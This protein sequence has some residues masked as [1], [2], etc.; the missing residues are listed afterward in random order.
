MRT[1]IA[2]LVAFLA[3]VAHADDRVSVAILLPIEG[4]KLQKHGTPT[5]YVE[6]HVSPEEI[7]TKHIPYRND[8]VRQVEVRE[9]GDT[10]VALVLLAAPFTQKKG[11]G[12]DHI[13]A[14]VELPSKAVAD[15]VLIRSKFGDK[16]YVG[17][18]ASNKRGESYVL[19]KR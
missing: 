9:Y 2:I 1:F 5:F 16:E 6:I 12:K 15:Q 8:A 11:P 17:E 19:L 7:S 10:A 3:T 18:W 13:G 4:F 14:S